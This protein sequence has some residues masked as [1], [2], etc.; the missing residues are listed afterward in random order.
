MMKER[1][2]V[3][4]G[5]GAISCV[6]NSVPE[7]WAAVKDGRCGLGNVTRFDTTGF[8]SAVAG[9]VKDFETPVVCSGTDSEYMR[10]DGRFA[11]CRFKKNKDKKSGN[12]CLCIEG[13]GV[14]FTGFDGEFVLI[15]VLEIVFVALC[16]QGTFFHT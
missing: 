4:T 16:C 13:D 2:V 8:R 6:G 3:V 11:L 9:E 7:L 15:D 10:F 5:C 14:L 12:W 1:R